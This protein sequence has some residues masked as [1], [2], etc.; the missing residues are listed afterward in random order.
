MITDFARAKSIDDALTLFKA[1][2][3]FIA[4]GTQVNNAAFARRLPPIEK[5]VSIED[6][7]LAG[8]ELEGEA[9]IIGATTTLQDIADSELVPEALK[10]A[11]D[12][13]RREV[14][15]TLRPLAGT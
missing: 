7:G 14:S 12:S 10:T 9:M 15:E 1:G 13:F 6:L 5:V 3:T 4:G 11:P 8:I 2:Y